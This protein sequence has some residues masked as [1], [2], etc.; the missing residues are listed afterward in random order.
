MSSCLISW[1]EKARLSPLAFSV[2]SGGKTHIPSAGYPPGIRY[3]S[4]G[5]PAVEK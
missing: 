5:D 4:A 1:D 2:S 3:I